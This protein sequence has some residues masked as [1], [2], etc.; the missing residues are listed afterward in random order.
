MRQD[1]R[2]LYEI[3]LRGQ[4]GESVLEVVDSIEQAQLACRRYIAK[5]FTVFYRAKVKR[6]AA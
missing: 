4:R 5:G 3:V 1:G 2:D 6:M